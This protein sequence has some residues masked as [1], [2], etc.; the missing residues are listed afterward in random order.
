MDMKMEKGAIHQGS[1]TSKRKGKEIV[2]KE[3]S[4]KEIWKNNWYGIRTAYSFSKSRVIPSITESSRK[5]ITMK[6]LRC[7]KEA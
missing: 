4:T 5:G 7:R 6:I 2:K 1:Y 3:R